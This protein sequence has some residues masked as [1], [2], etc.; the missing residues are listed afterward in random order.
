MQSPTTGAV[1]SDRFIPI[2]TVD[3]AAVGPV[4][5]V[6]FGPDVARYGALWQMIGMR[7]TWPF[8]WL[9]G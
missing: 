5:V 7:D 1:Y 6:E 4:M 2:N 8:A 3:E 9:E